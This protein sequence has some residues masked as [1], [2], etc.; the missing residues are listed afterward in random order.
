[1]Q[2]KVSSHSDPFTKTGART[3]DFRTAL[4]S[5]QGDTVT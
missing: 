4:N 3:V 2:T 1:M 5:D